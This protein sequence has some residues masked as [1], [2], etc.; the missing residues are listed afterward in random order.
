MLLLPGEG[1]RW[2]SRAGARHACGEGERV[3]IA[4]AAVA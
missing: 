4:L 1:L 3:W 2:G